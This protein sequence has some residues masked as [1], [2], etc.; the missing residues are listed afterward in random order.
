C[1]T[2]ARPASR[3]R[4]SPTRG[5]IKS[6]TFASQWRSSAI[7]ALF[8]ARSSRTNAAQ[9]YSKGSKATQRN[10]HR[11]L[12]LQHPFT[13]CASGSRLSPVKT[14]MMK[15]FAPIL[16]TLMSTTS[17]LN[18]QTATEP[19]PPVAKKIHKETKIHGQVLPDDY[20]WLR[21]K[22]NPEVASYLE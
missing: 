1:R 6:A 18:G 16:I 5:P 12:Q 13:I 19:Q 11:V 7:C 8:T 3:A 15:S 20:G 22:S 21:E 17:L 10:A 4:H 14:S 2:S 9:P